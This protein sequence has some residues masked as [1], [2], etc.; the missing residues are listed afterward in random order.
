MFFSSID[1]CTKK[2]TENKK[3]RLF[4]VSK[5]C[6]SYWFDFRPRIFYWIRSALSFDSSTANLVDLNLVRWFG[7]TICFV[8]RWNSAWE[9]NL[10]SND[11]SIIKY[12]RSIE[13][14]SSRWTNH[15]SARKLDSVEFLVR[16]KIFLNNLWKN[17]TFHRSTKIKFFLFQ[18]T[19]RTDEDEIFVSPLDFVERKRRDELFSSK[20]NKNK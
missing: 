8:C 12:R 15:C 6:R 14:S 20:C 16:W 5:R 2:S 11:V 19:W 4:F 1:Y 10:S 18:R 13:D 9:I 17:K 3:K 7:P